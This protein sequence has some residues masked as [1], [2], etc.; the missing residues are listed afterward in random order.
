M[1]TLGRFVHA[2]GGGGGKKKKGHTPN[3]VC[4][5]VQ[6]HVGPHDNAGGILEA[7]KQSH[8]PQRN[9]KGGRGEAQEREM[10][11]L[12]TGLKLY[13][14]LSG[15]RKDTHLQVCDSVQSL[16]GPHNNAIGVLEA[17][18]KRHV[19]QPR[20]RRA[21]RVLRSRCLHTRV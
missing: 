10:L 14:G 21:D 6:T 13:L 17:L 15:E 16:V 4:D 7:L 12:P 3:Q 20:V 11:D 1:R 8:V 19:T 5:W 9:G 18:K 2:R